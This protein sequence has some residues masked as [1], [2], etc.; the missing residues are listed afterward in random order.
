MLQNVSIGTNMQELEPKQLKTAIRACSICRKGFE[1]SRP[2][3]PDWSQICPEC[4]YVCECGCHGSLVKG[5]EANC[6]C[7]VTNAQP[8]ALTHSYSDL[9]GYEKY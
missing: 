6:K 3:S 9:G 2:D 7:C 5:V 4:Q 8:N 1:S